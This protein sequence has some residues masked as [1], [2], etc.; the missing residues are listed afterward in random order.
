MALVHIN[1]GPKKDSDS[2]PWCTELTWQYVKLLLLGSRNIS[3]TIS[4]D[5]LLEL[6]NISGANACKFLLC[7]ETVGH[8]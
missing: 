8:F 5:K 2:V 3:F 1:F 7:K 6:L 4:S